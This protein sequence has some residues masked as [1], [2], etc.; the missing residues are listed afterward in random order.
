[1]TEPAVRRNLAD[2]S[3]QTWDAVI[4]GAGPAGS[5]SAALLAAQG[6]QVL[7]VE[8]SHWPRD[9]ACGGCVNAAATA[10]LLSMGLGEVLDG[11]IVLTRMALHVGKCGTTIALPQ[12]IAIER[13][14]LDE[15]LVRLATSRGCVFVD[16]VAA[17]LVPA[18]S[19]E[20]RTV[21]LKS[22]GT[23][24][25]V[26]ARVVLACDGLG[27]TSLANES[28]AR[29]EQDQPIRLGFA[30]TVEHAGTLPAGTIGMY[31][32]TNGYV[33][34]VRLSDGHFHVGASLDPAACHARHGCPAAVVREILAECGLNEWQSLEK[35]KFIGTGPLTRRRR[36]VG[37]H[38]VLA[39]GDACGYVEPFTGEGISWAIRS[40][41]EV[42]KLLPNQAETWP[43][44]L[45]DR[46]GAIHSLE[47]VRR[48][49]WCRG[50]RGILH[51]PALAA[52]CV[53]VTRH[54]PWASEIMARQISA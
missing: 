50:L 49:R 47:I 38:R 4:V 28:W 29:F 34:L 40:A 43:G 52:A 5:V 23:S 19:G 54:V 45:A 36:A 26:Q 1:M 2:I 24:V 44:D 21:R 9:K 46:W 14:Q 17:Q 15:L 48:Q 8:K 41:R 10:M 3:R 11:G 25:E 51:R 27:G 42:V 20:L 37:G 6:W 39:V 12:G 31:V 32:G 7:L 18:T 35:A 13:R 33:G 16:A 30:A 22:G 53:R